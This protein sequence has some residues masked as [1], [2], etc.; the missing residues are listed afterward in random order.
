MST[1]C[2]HV[3]MLDPQLTLD[4]QSYDKVSGTHGSFV[5]QA[6]VQQ[7]VASAVT[8]EENKT[9]NEINFNLFN[10]NN[11]ICH[12]A[13]NTVQYPTYFSSYSYADMTVSGLL[14]LSSHGPGTLELSPQ[15]S[16]GSHPVTNLLHGSRVHIRFIIKLRHRI[17]HSTSSVQVRRGQQTR[18]STLTV[19]SVHHRRR[20]TSG[21]HLLRQLDFR[22]RCRRSRLPVR[23]LSCR[24]R[25]HRRPSRAV[26]MCSTIRHRCRR[27]LLL[28]L[29][30]R[31]LL[32]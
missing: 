5:E 11:F 13:S 31:R 26:V 1:Q 32:H 28:L 17:R 4:P 15:V 2:V 30:H 14:S 25:L 6:S 23:P 8:H 20:S 12:S 7:N 10:E 3:S 29:R 18:S 22:F 21:Y 27:I 9:Q 19:A 24:T 16:V